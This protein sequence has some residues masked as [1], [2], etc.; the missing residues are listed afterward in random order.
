[1]YLISID[2]ATAIG[3][4]AGVNLVKLVNGWVVWIR[5]VEWGVVRTSF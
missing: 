4:A 2:P 3:T 1:V 5:N